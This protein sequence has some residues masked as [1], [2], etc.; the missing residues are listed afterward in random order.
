MSKEK[1]KSAP[2]RKC[3]VCAHPQAKE[4]N[5]MIN[6][7]VSF[8]RISSQF[9]MA[10]RSVGRHT[11]NCLKLEIAALI[12]AKKIE[13][14][15]DHYQEIPEQLDFAKDLRAAARKCLTHPET[16]EIVLLPRADEVEVVY[17]DYLDTSPTGAPKKK[18]DNLDILLER[19]KKGGIEPT[20]TIIKHVDLRSYA[21]DAIRT[22]DI[23]LDKF[24][25]VQGAYAKDN[26]QKQPVFS[27]TS[28]KQQLIQIAI[29]QAAEWNEDVGEIY[30][31][32]V[33]LRVKRLQENGKRSAR[34]ILRRPIRSWR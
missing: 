23:V 29:K 22:I 32:L 9:G 15:I 17:E 20:R 2:G 4:I 33:P 30:L 6:D 24:A 19:V 12:K 18:T 28:H 26:E 8:R 25:K 14:A 11:E 1:S 27:V 16:G 7:A 34:R 13:N 21:L 10:D 3:S 31:Y 5:S